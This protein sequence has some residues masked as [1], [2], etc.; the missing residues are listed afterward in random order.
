MIEPS[1]IVHAIAAHATWK[2]RLHEAIRTGK[3]AWTVPGVRVDDQCEFGTWLRSLPPDEQTDHWRTVMRR[4]AAFHRAAADVLELALTGR[5]SE[6]ED[7]IAPGSSFAEA[8]KELTLA[9]MAWKND[10]A[11]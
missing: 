1:N 4:H 9:M 10:L 6:G 8:S 5:S 11:A 3:S 2:H 7:A